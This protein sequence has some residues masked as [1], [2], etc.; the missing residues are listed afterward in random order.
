MNL[1]NSIEKI[2]ERILKIVKNGIKISFVFCLIACYILITYTIIG[3]INAYYIG[4][5]FLKS[6]IFFIIGFVICGLAFNKI[7]KE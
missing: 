4:I 1:K 2:D 3:E 7:M 5:S 6:G